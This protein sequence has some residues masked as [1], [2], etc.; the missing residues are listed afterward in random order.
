MVCDLA[1]RG[2]AEVKTEPGST[3]PTLTREDWDFVGAYYN[4]VE[5]PHYNQFLKLAFT[6]EYARSCP[7]LV[8]IYRSTEKRVHLVDGTWE[9]YLVK[10]KP[11]QVSPEECYPYFEPIFDP[12]LLDPE[13]LPDF[14]F[15]LLIAPPGF[16]EKPYVKMTAKPNDKTTKEPN[17]KTNYLDYMVARGDRSLRPRLILSEIGKLGSC[18]TDKSG[19]L[20]PEDEAVHLRLDWDQTNGTLVRA[21][22]VWLEKKRPRK[23]KEKPGKIET[24]PYETDLKALGVWRLMR[25]HGGSIKDARNFC[26]SQGGNAPFV[27]DEDW[28]R[29]YRRAD[30]ILEDF[31]HRI[32]FSTASS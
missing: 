10:P 14:E 2:V 21:F 30:E 4:L 20:V 26:I 29:A 15:D 27:R 25:A 6:Y 31:S 7:A 11:G 5:Q 22:R 17:D 28:R 9:C 13:D 3:P 18:W 16:P 12:Y 1:R 23:E 32:L 24:R 19:R 8:E